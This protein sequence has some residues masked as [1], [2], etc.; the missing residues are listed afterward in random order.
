MTTGTKINGFHST[1]GMGACYDGIVIL[2]GKR[3]PFG[4]F[5]KTLARVNPIDL[6]IMAS[7]AALDTCGVKGTDIDQVVFA[8]V[9]QSGP[10]AYYLARHIGLYSGVPVERPAL[11]VQR[12]CGSGFETI[13][14]AAEQIALGKADVVLVGG[15]ENMSLN[16]TA[17]YG[18]RMGHDMG[19]PGFVD[20]LYEELLDPACGV[21]MGQTAENLAEKY[22]ITREEADRFAVQSQDNFRKAKSDGFFEGEIV[23][24]R[25]CTFEAGTLKPR[26]IKL[27]RG[28]EE[29]REDEHPRETSVEKLAKLPAVFKKDGVQSAGNSSGIVDGACALI[30]ASE[31]AARR[32][33]VTPLGRLA[34][35]VSVGVSPEMM[36]IGPAPA[37]RYLLE[38]AGKSLS[39]I[40]Y[41]EINE[42]FA[43]QALSVVKDAELNPGRVN[44]NGGSIAVGHPLAATGARLSL[45]L[46]RHLQR[47]GAHFGIAS[48][49][50]G[51][52]QGTA[53]LLER[54]A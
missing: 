48:A 1:Q 10:D 44:V 47:A 52:G 45:T 28:V 5:T 54:Q 43:A 12:I 4:A 50:I 18:L 17:A 21:T 46:L 26:K 2:G 24:V 27:P 41:F 37:I 35:S 23:P 29:L 30:V 38:I 13:V 22:G 51:G 14:H 3:T 36:G 25:S 49:C 40:D 33:G 11:M 32:L 31:A 19:N 42:A 16:P 15:T 7:R 9:A 6:G 53:L 8:N 39:A 34:A 20:T